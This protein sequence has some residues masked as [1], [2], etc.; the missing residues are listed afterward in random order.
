M[1]FL[2]DI[3]R[4]NGYSN[5]QICRALNPPLRVAQPDDKPDSVAFLLTVGQ[6]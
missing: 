2:R 1:V 5:W 4:Q 6:Y 3:F